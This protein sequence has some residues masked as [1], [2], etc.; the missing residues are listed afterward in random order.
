M[1][2]RK[3]LKFLGLIPAL[4]IACQGWPFK[5]KSKPPPI[6]RYDPDDPETIASG[7]IYQPLLE[8]DNSLAN[9]VVDVKINGEIL[10][11]RFGE[12]MEAGLHPQTLRCLRK[13]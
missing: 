7:S 12:L 6:K 8:H 3:F 5:P 2:R 4:P 1:K 9:M 10:K 11:I 13:I